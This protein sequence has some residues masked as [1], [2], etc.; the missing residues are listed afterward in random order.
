M[1]AAP[2]SSRTPS[3][4]GVDATGLIRFLDALDADPHIRPHAL[5]VLRD[6]HRIAEGSWA[7]F[8]S[9]RVQL[10]YSLSKSFTT[11]AAGFAWQEGL[12]DLDA[13]VLSYFPELDADVT[14]PRSRAMKVRHLASM[15]SGHASD[16]VDRARDLDPVDLVRGFLMIS[17]DAEPG[18]LFAYNQPCTYTLAAIVQRAAG[19]TL[20]EYLRPRLLDPLGIGDVAWFE[21]PAGRNLGF[22]GLHAT[23]DAVARLGELYRA[24]GMWGDE[25]LL[26][27]DWVTLATSRQI[28]TPPVGS[29]DW[30]QGYGFQ[31][32]MARHGYRGDGAFG[33]FCVVVPE[34]GLVVA[35]TS[36]SE[37]MQPVLD[38]LW[39]H[40]LP[41]I[42]APADPVAD[43]ALAA[44][45]AT[46]AVP[47]PSRDAAPANPEAWA[48]RVFTEIETPA[49]GFA[50]F[51]ESVQ[52]RATE[53]GDQWYLGIDDHLGHLDLL[54]G[55]GAWSIADSAGVPVAASG[56]WTAAGDLVVEVMFLESPHTLEITC[57]ADSVLARVS[58]RTPPLHERMPSTQH[59]P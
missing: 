33:Q 28:A 48:S 56:G 1:T 18:S 49:G 34:A 24:G 13:T 22:S 25:R 19:T 23:V 40:V 38:A 47:A 41:A 46:L 52:V 8:A 42:D 11:T 9:E 45:L 17:P 57:L 43:E 37:P 30:E 44:R 36:E 35:L 59:R 39:A 15:T 10:L 51:V 21:E 26:S 31:F 16:T 27:E 53:A 2:L 4:A 12:L 7:P 54:F 29:P 58:W 3:E 6:G 32:W 50:A 14:D 55:T 20:V 5:V